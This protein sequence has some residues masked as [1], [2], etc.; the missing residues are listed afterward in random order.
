M[1]TAVAAARRRLGTEDRPHGELRLVVGGDHITTLAK[2]EFGAA[3][4]DF[5]SKNRVSQD[6]R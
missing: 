4:A 2:P 3:V 5:V 1:R 6:R